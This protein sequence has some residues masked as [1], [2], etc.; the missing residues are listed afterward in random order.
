MTTAVRTRHAALLRPPPMTFAYVA[1]WLFVLVYC[2]RPSDWIVGAANIPFA[3]IVG[4]LVLLAF[5]T[6]LMSGALSA[7]WWSRE[8]V[9][10][11]LLYAQLCL[12]VPF[13]I[14]R[15]G[16]FQVVVEEFTK[17]VLVTLAIIMATT[18][19]VRLRRLLFVQTVSVA[20]MAI[21]AASGS[22]GNVQSAIGNRTAG[23]VGGIFENPNDFALVLAMTFPFA[24]TFAF[25]TKR[26]VVKVAWVVVMLIMVNTSMAT[27]SR[28]GL[29]ALLTAAM[30]S[31]WEFAVRARRLRWALIVVPLGIT[32]ILLS[33]PAGLSE[34][35][36]TIF[37][38]DADVTG[39]AAQRRG[40]FIRSLEATAQHPLVGIGPGNFAIIS[41]S[42]HGTHNSYT[43]LSAEAGLP[44]MLFFLLLGSKSWSNL[45]LAQRYAAEDPEV[46]LWAASL[47]SSLAAFAVGACFASFAYHHFPYFIV[48]Y[49]GALFKMSQATYL[50]KQPESRPLRRIK[51]AS[52]CAES[53]AS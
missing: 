14:W 40:L 35:M 23:L 28:A 6:G 37:E 49:A 32:V 34:R 43:Q 20:V 10:L 53:Q 11:L 17:V 1:I 16:S 19:V 30:V 41:G 25:R 22:G 42:W 45:R 15:G 47:L 2:A 36:A 39:S 13:S 52:P 26:L 46:R 50:A 24:F 7:S 44:A 48:G 18:S 38:P 3:K 9:L 29:L 5:L 21:L 27:Y 8:V 4:L 33:S 31:M 12:S 51:G